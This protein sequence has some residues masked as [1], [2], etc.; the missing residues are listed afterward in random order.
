MQLELELSNAR[1]KE[2]LYVQ[3]ALKALHRA[4]V[5]TIA[6]KGGKDKGIFY[7]ANSLNLRLHRTFPPDYTNL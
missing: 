2:E 1:Q 7:F 6:E 5:R 4:V 3:I